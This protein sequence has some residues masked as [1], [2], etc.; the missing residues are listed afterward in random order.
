MVIQ[1]T[2]RPTAS[3]TVKH[4]ARAFTAPRVVSVRVVP[5]PLTTAPMMTKIPAT[6][7]AV[8]K[9]TMREETAEPNTLTAWFAPKG[10]TEKQSRA[11][12]QPFDHRG[13]YI[14]RLM[15]AIARR[16]QTSSASSEILSM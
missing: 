15:V 14:L 6:M 12:E 10:P 8:R 7:A 5:A 9:R 3:A 2:V 1:A 4:P 11:D 13:A 16:S